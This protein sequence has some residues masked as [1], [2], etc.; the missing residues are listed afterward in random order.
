MLVDRRH[1]RRRRTCELSPQG[2]PQRAETLEKPPGVLVLDLEHHTALGHGLLVLLVDG[3]QHGLDHPALEAWVSPHGL[4][5]D[6]LDATIEEPE[7]AVDNAVVLATRHPGL[8]RPPRLLERGLHPDAELGIDLG[9]RAPEAIPE[10]LDRVRG[11]HVGPNGLAAPVDLAAREE[12]SFRLLDR[13][14]VVGLLVEVART[15]ARDGCGD[16]H[17]QEPE[18]CNGP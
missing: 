4:G 11:V 10:F 18:T 9:H 12:V 17:E 13:G 14:D 3:D 15:E 7:R 5:G 6:A 16:R 2:L 1:R 8:D